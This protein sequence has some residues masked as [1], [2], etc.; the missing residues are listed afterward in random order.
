M[1]FAILTSVHTC[2]VANLLQARFKYHRA[3]SKI[4]FSYASDINA[5]FFIVLCSQIFPS[6]PPSPKRLIFQMEQSTNTRWF[7]KKYLGDMQTSVGILDY[8]LENI[9]H[10]KELGIQS[11]RTYYLPIGANSTF[12]PQPTATK[13]YDFVFYGDYYSSERR[14]KFIQALQKQYRV[15]ILQDVFEEELFRAITSAKAVIN[16]H[17]YENPLLETTRICECLSL[18]MP[19]LSESTPDITDYP[20]FD[21]AVTYFKEG[22]IDDLMIKARWFLEN[23]PSKESIK[24][25]A[26]Q[27]E[28]KFN[29]HFDQIFAELGL[30]SLKKLPHPLLRWL[31]FF[32]S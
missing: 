13:D 29:I 15:L 23:L 25:A 1:D 28:A 32:Q 19:V 7:T 17:Y 31:R 6:L 9:K 18:G 27:S 3:S 10:L 2:Y 16:L 24:N 20:E 21:S 11:T 30:I 5:N 8:S 14:Q 4:F 22:S 26:I 12:S